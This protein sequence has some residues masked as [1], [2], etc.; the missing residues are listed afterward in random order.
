MRAYAPAFARLC[1]NAPLMRAY[2]L[3][4]AP[5]CG[6]V[7]GLFALFHDLALFMGLMRQP[8][9]SCVVAHHVCVLM[10]QPVRPKAVAC[11]SLC[12]LMR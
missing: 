9:R 11:T 3:A 8:M 12:A 10:R 4:D 7:M 1:G 2:E 6:S 5:L